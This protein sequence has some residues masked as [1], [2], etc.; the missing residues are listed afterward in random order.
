[1]TGRLALLLKGGQGG[2][3]QLSSHEDL[4]SE[5]FITPFFPGLPVGKR[6]SFRTEGAT[7][8]RDSIRPDPMELL[9]FCFADF[10]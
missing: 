10:G 6:Q 4:T 7:E 3:N 2:P 8:L 1:L 9:E 5:D